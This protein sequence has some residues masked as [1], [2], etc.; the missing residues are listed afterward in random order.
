[1]GSGDAEEINLTLSVLQFLVHNHG[2]N[3]FLRFKMTLKSLLDYIDELSFDQAC[4][5]YMVLFKVAFNCYSNGDPS[6]VDELFIL[7]R[8]QISHPHH[9]YVILGIAGIATLIRA[10][11]GSTLSDSRE[12]I[13]SIEL[14]RLTCKFLSTQD[15]VVGFISDIYL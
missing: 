7:V 2:P 11:P 14:L 13:T 15:T 10:L 6:F 3:E 8:K 9:Q 4:S 12:F 5:L 1:M